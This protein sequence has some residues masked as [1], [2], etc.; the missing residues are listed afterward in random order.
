MSKPE[1]PEV[2]EDGDTPLV[3]LSNPQ[4]SPATRGLADHITEELAR[5]ARDPAATMPMQPKEKTA[6]LFGRRVHIDRSFGSW[7]VWVWLEER[8]GSYVVDVRL[9]EDVSWE[10]DDPER[11]SMG[12]YCR[13]SA[14]GR[15]AM[16]RAGF[17]GHAVDLR[18]E[19][20]ELLSGAYTVYAFLEGVPG[21]PFII[22]YRLLDSVLWNEACP[23]CVR[24]A[25]E[26]S[27]DPWEE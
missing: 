19:G 5:L 13:P 12:E 26:G 25:H 27:C 9:L 6:T 20:F 8:H 10:Q 7:A 24:S 22:D 14:A 16:G 3:P 21:G 15:P 4:L 11:P 17:L 2:P 18:G 1:N 23:R